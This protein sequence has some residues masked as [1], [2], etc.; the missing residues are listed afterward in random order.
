MNTLNLLAIEGVQGAG[1][2]TL[3]LQLTTENIASYGT[4]ISPIKRP[5]MFNQD[6]GGA[7]LSLMTDIMWFS[8]AV[9]TA[10]LAPCTQPVILDRFI[11]SQWVYG[12][13]RGDNS[14]VHIDILTS[15][16]N[17]FINN[18]FNSIPKGILERTVTKRAWTI[19]EINLV[20]L[21]LLPD[22]SEIS[23]RRSLE[24][25]RKF[26]Y[27]VEQE[28]LYYSKTISVLNDMGISNIVL[29]GTELITEISEKINEA[30]L[31]FSS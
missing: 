17:L 24:P 27:T 16:L 6:D 18:L 15:M 5:R 9:V 4:L 10:M 26:T 12:S 13:L 19:Q 2:S 31:S 3:G 22:V 30:F 20:Y 28:L 1:K 8:S 29:D 14:F 23:R 21:L 7:G 11:L 25:Y